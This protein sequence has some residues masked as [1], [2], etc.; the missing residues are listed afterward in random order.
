MMKRK[1]IYGLILVIMI[2]FVAVPL[3]SAGLNLT[4]QFGEFTGECMEVFYTTPIAPY[5]SAEHAYTGQYDA[6]RK[7][8]SLKIDAEAARSLSGLRIDFPNTAQL[9]SIQDI[10]VSSAG[11]VKKRY[12]PCAFFADGNVDAMHGIEALDAAPAAAKVF[13]LTDGNDPYLVLGDTLV[14]DIADCRSRYRLTRLAFCVLILL[15]IHFYRRPIARDTEEE[16]DAHDE[17]VNQTG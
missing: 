14:Q 10:S 3:P 9:L 6:D 2:V 12:H 11:T 8:V 1:Y 13:I 17:N 4:I 5:Y 15:G 7:S 16:R